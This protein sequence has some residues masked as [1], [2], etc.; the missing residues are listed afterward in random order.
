MGFLLG[1][2]FL[3]FTGSLRRKRGEIADLLRASCREAPLETSIQPNKLW[4]HRGMIWETT[5]SGH[6]LST[7]SFRETAAGR[8]FAGSPDFIGPE[9]GFSAKEVASRQDHVAL[10]GWRLPVSPEWCKGNS[11]LQH[12]D[13]DKPGE[14]TLRGPVLEAYG[15]G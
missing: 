12:G 9:R 15:E 2:G 3:G 13:G 4:T 8:G 10:P 14:V 11:A 1:G 5:P 7:L 6:L